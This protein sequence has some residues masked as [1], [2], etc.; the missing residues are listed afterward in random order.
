MYVYFCIFEILYIRY[1]FSYSGSSD[2][3]LVKIFN[4]RQTGR[5]PGLPNANTLI[6]QVIHTLDKHTLP[7]GILSGNL[8][9]ATVQIRSNAGFPSCMIS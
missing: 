1:V 7:K 8:Q 3:L 4:C 6:L 2:K 9:M 5:L